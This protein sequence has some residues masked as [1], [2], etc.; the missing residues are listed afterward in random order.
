MHKPMTS[1]LINT[2]S[3]TRG[4]Y[5][6]KY[7]KL[8]NPVAMKILFLN[9]GTGEHMIT[10]AMNNYNVAALYHCATITKL[11]R[12]LINSSKTSDS[13]KRDKT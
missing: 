12:Q 6:T 5:L 1:A 11:E 10:Q 3:V 9:R 4:V 7:H 8:V 2:N 13:Q